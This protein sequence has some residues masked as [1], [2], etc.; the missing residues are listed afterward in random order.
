V[1]RGLIDLFEE[2]GKELDDEDHWCRF[3]RQHNLKGCCQQDRE[4]RLAA[5]LQSLCVGWYMPRSTLGRHLTLLW[6][7]MRRDDF[8]NS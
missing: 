2:E 7:R 4:V 1:P 5:Q 8:H 6:Y 3:K